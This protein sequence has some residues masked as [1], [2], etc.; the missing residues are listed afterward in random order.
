MHCPN[1]NSPN[2]RK[3]S[4]IVQEGTS[5]VAVTA[6]MTPAWPGG[7]KQQISGTQTVRTALAQRFAPPREPTGA[8]YVL[9]FFLVIF[10]GLYAAF[11][12]APIVYRHYS[13]VHA[14]VAGVAALCFTFWILMKGWD[15]LHYEVLGGREASARH[16]EALERWRRSWHCGQC[17][18]LYIQ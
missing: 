12:I 3:L 9:A 7:G 8:L 2:V 15:K 10:A 17:G 13:L 6:T 11:Q 18:I 14:L 16:R 5:Q 4:V 1:C